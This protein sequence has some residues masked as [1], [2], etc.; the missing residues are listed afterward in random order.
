MR[1]SEPSLPLEIARR[2]PSP[3][4]LWLKYR[5]ATCEAE[6]GLYEGGSASFAVFPACLEAQTRQRMVDL[7]AT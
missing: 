4:G 5:D 6:R 2:L 7:Q 3:S 1:R